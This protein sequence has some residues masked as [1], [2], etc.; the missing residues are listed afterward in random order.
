MKIDSPDCDVCCSGREF[1]T[2]RFPDATIMVAEGSLPMSDSG[3]IIDVTDLPTVGANSVIVGVDVE[4]DR[5]LFQRG[6]NGAVYTYQLNGT[7]ELLWAS[8]SAAAG[9]SLNFVKYH[10]SWGFAS[11]MTAS[12]AAIMA[13]GSTG[14]IVH[15]PY[16]QAGNFPAG[17]GLSANRAFFLPHDFHVDSAG[18]LYARTARISDGVSPPTGRVYTYVLKNDDINV[19]DDDPVGPLSGGFYYEIDQLSS[20]GPLDPERLLVSLHHDGTDLHTVQIPASM[21]NPLAASELFDYRCP[22]GTN[23]ETDA[24]DLFTIFGA[25]SQADIPLGNNFPNAPTYDAPRGRIWT[26]SWIYTLDGQTIAHIT[27]QGFGVT[28]AIID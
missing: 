23:T 5:L 12:G 18:N 10:H 25:S 6:D 24:V 17:D 20:S 4:R 3:L 16:T 1:W 26:G 22:T 28:V 13:L 19:G 11:A 27:F 14:A 21:N 8:T 9:Q 2:G 7:V 15:G